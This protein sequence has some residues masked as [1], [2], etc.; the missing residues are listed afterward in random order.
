[1]SDP[2]NQYPSYPSAPPG[3]TEYYPPQ[4]GQYPSP[5]YQY[6]QPY[7]PQAPR[8]H[9]YTA[10]PNQAPQFHVSEGYGSAQG[11]ETFGPPTG[12]YQPGAEGSQSSTYD[13][14]KGGA[15]MSY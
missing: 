8:D 5:P 12:T 7:G 1:M 6:Q 9:A 2:Y 10:G 13:T 14:G 11:N 15:N 3:G 4:D